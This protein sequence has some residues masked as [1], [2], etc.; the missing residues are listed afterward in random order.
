MSKEFKMTELGPLPREW[1]LA[2]LGDIADKMRAGGTP[3]RK[4]TTYWHGEIPLVL[5]E[6]ITKSN[7]YLH[8][9]TETITQDGLNN[10]SSWCVPSGNLIY[11]LYGTVG[12]VVINEMPVAITQNMAGIIPNHDIVDTNFLYYCLIHAN[13]N[14]WNLIDITVHSHISITK[15]KKIPIPLPPLPEQKKIAAVLSAVQEAKEKTEAV[16]K[17]TREM[18]KSLMKHLFTYGPVSLEEAENIPLKETEIGLVPEEWEV[19]PLVE[20]AT[21]QR[22][23]DLPKQN[24]VPGKYPVVG[25]SGIITHH[26]EYVCRGPGVVTGRSGSIGNLIYVEEDYWP[27]NT[28]LYVKDFHSN[29]PRFIHY[30]LQLVDFRKYATGVSVPTLNRNFVHVALLPLPPLPIQQRISDILIGV[31][32]K[33]EV[34]EN[35]KKALGELFKTLLSNLM[36]G[37]IRVHPVR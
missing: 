19:K 13:Q 16:I 28:G 2:S 36:T 15:A 14:L 10:S 1:A 22:G 7:K 34:E 20:I 29:H 3:S 21:L 11:S 26:N 37:R 35:K 9:T 25:S 4:E 24:Q 8:I 31:D 6:D 32:K 17:A 30:L 33:I 12:R 18:K 5:I 27:H 23:K